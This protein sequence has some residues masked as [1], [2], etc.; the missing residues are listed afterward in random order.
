MRRLLASAEGRNQPSDTAS[1]EFLDHTGSRNR[2]ERSIGHS[3]QIK[4]PRETPPKAALRILGT[5]GVSNRPGVT[6]VA[7]AV[8]RVRPHKLYRPDVA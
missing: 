3:E 8:G 5:C 1:A 7:A 4:V 2:Y 6:D